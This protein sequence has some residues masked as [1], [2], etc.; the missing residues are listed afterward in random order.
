LIEVRG[1]GSPREI[2]GVR[3]VV[4]VVLFL[5]VLASVAVAPPAYAAF[6]NA[7]PRGTFA[8]THN[9]VVTGGSLRTQSNDGNACAVGT[10]STAT[11]SGIPA[12]STI[13][14]AYLYWG[15]SGPTPDNSVT[16]GPS[17]NTATISPQQT[18]TDNFAVPGSYDFDF[19][20]GFRDVTSQVAGNG[21][22]TFGN[23]SVATTNN[24]N[25]SQYSNYCANA[26]VVAGWSLVVVY[27]NPAERY[28]YTRV[29]DGLRYFRGSSVTTTQSGFRVPDLVDGKVTVVTWEGDPDATTST[30][31]DGY[32]EELSFDG[33]QL[34][35]I[36][37]DGNNNTYNSTIGTPS[38]CSSTTYGVDVDTYSVTPF[39]HA[40]QTGATLE[41]SS[42]N[43][44]V[45]LAAQVIS[46]TNT[47]VADLGISKTH[48][49]NFTAGANGTFSIGVHNFG[50]EIAVG[51]TTV[52]DTLPTGMS[53]VSGSGSGWSCSAAGQAVTCTS[54]TATLAVGADLPSLDLTV[55]VAGDAPAS[56]QNTATVSHPMFD[57]TGGNQAA[58]DT[59]AI[60]HSNLST[61]TKSVS[62]PNG[63]DAVPGDK[64]RYTITLKETAGAAA[65]NVSVADGLPANTTGLAVVSV[66]SGSVDASTA[67]Q[68]AVSG[69]SI[70][71][72]GT[73]T[74][75]FDVTVA[76]VAPG[77]AIDN[78]ATISNPGGPG[79]SPA[80]A[81]VVVSQSQV[82]VPASG[83]KV[84][85]LYDDKTMS[86][87][88]TG[89]AATSGVQVGANGYVDWTLSPGLV[90]QLTLAGNAAVNL[91]A[92]CNGTWL[93][94]FAAPSIT[95]ELRY[96]NTSVATSAAQS[97]TSQSVT[98]ASLA[99]TFSGPIDIPAGTAVVLRIRNGGYSALQVYQYN[100][101]QSTLSFL[102]P[103]V[104]NVDSVDVYS[105]A[106]NGSTQPARYLEGNSV[107]V[108]AV[109]SDPFGPADIT[110]ATLLLTDAGGTVRVNGVAMSLKATG[111][112]TKT[113][114][115]SYLIPANP[116]IGT[117]T[118]KVTAIEGTEVD[119]GGSPV[120]S[121]ARTQLVTVEGKVN[122]AKT[123]GSG[124]PAGNAVTLAIAGG[125]SAAA[126]SSTVGAATVAATATAAAGATLT[127]SE[128]FT[129]GT[130]G[131]YTIGLACTRV[132]DGAAVP[133]TGNGLSRTITMPNDSAVACAY[134]NRLSVPLTVVKASRVISDPINGT[135][136]PK[137]I[138]GAIVEYE[139][140]VTNPAANPV[141]ADSVVL[142]DPIPPQ[143]E[144]RVADL[145]GAGSG[146]VAF[147]NGAPASGLAYTFA[148][149]SSAIDD[150]D[151][152]N[153]AGATWNYT[154]M[155][156]G[157]DGVDPA[158]TNIRINPKGAFNANNAQFRIRFRA[159]L[160]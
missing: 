147:A 15:G 57:G 50:P 93:C 139:I 84:L 96:G 33:N 97:L 159:R 24:Y 132:R 42:G 74:I 140:I 90:K 83:G 95:A 143:L 89:N 54:S 40:G 125:T 36:G 29:Y 144:M 8:G 160:K 136:L 138:P 7:T 133:V 82:A 48:S 116:R 150:I 113:F 30:S 86:R 19:F 38:S 87:V 25:G 10:T 115:G 151:F 145:G 64:L 91:R 80:A 34:R 44:L 114:E 124:A 58:T 103:T 52:T 158:V 148:S 16:F 101:G 1:R 35:N 157:S 69:I 78:T 110:G 120:I 102:T 98:G 47:P 85:Y 109:V 128:A 21:S 105:T 104:I 12:G 70:A 117:W 9:Y 135:T 81:T 153:D 5:L 53:F 137:A 149:L 59:V 62:D 111:A 55:A 49:G 22:Y 94:G 108:R 73:A 27:S 118:A 146:P 79:A 66:P 61:S 32:N 106:Y 88:Q 72:N 45:L 155:P 152:S 67:S 92:K 3:S 68:L 13:L 31:L 141:D 23:L 112:T 28:R 18:F 123:W 6:D 134:T 107:Y 100:G 127:L 2:A 154:P 156:S 131:N 63:G 76:N 20:G 17:G 126:G 77:T 75:V 43:D 4:A 51:Q 121:H 26:T 129:S 56:L 14:A 122:L 41:Y 119:G 37:C 46:T 60:V 71:A 11:L 39:L 65:S 130:P 142:A 99:L